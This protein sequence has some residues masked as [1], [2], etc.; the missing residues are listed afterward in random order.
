MVK[1]RR[2]DKR[3]RDQGMRRQRGRLKG[4]EEE[5]LRKEAA[6]YAAVPISRPTAHKTTKEKGRTSHLDKP[7]IPGDQPHTLDQRQR[8][9]GNSTL[10][11]AR[12]MAKQRAKEKVKER[13]S[14][15]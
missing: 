9:G 11:K 10:N 6:G 12:G 8:N 3:K 14:T 13:A 5:E 1:A 15:R 7:G 4:K 2:Q